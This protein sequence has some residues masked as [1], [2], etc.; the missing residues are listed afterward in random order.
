MK[1]FKANPETVKA[2][3]ATKDYIT[4][5]FPEFKETQRVMNDEKFKAGYWFYAG[6][7]YLAV[8]LAPGDDVMSKIPTIGLMTRPGNNYMYVN[9]RSPKGATVDQLRVL[10]HRLKE[11][12]AKFIFEKL[13]EGE[14]YKM[15]MN[16]G[17]WNN[18]I[19]KTLTDYYPV[20]RQWYTEVENSK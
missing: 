7:D 12:G 10:I 13:R 3:A 14:T 17:S 4:K 15:Y 11:A 6:S 2:H 8:R 16:G 20:I 19:H 5:N 9:L 18:A 1:Q